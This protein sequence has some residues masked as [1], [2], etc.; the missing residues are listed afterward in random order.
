MDDDDL[1]WMLD[2][3]FR[4]ECYNCAVIEEKGG[5]HSSLHASKAFYKDG[6]RMQDLDY[7]GIIRPRSICPKCMK[8][9]VFL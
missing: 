2:C 9:E 3:I 5:C 1:E 8:L 4:I 6:W 7:D